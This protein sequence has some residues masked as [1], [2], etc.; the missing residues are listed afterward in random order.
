M[1]E[2]RFNTAGIQPERKD[3]LGR[4]EE[5]YTRMA[6]SVKEMM[7][8][9]KRLLAD[10]SH[11]LRSPLGRMEVSA[12]LLTDTCK[13]T[14]NGQGVRQAEMMAAEIRSMTGL[15]R[16]L[17]EYARINLPEFRLEFALEAP[18]E[19]IRDLF[20]RNL[21]IMAK[22]GLTLD[23][24]IPGDL[25]RIYMDR[26]RILIVLQNFLDNAM[27][28]SPAGG[29]IIIGAK[30]D[31]SHYQLFVSN[32]GPGIPPEYGDRIFDPLFRADKSRN[33]NTGGLGLGLAI[34]RRIVALHGGQIRHTRENKRTVFSIDLKD[35]TL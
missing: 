3:E 5:T 2:G 12:E 27:Q 26:D 15:V 23:L 10:I 14:E 17:S 28:Q 8:S 33:R 13:E 20:S 4:L 29:R 35:D 21:H 30:T 16:A 32:P 7:A 18:E 31:P 25:R 11:E 6:A 22:R 34:S 24:D 1:A 19:L 9:K